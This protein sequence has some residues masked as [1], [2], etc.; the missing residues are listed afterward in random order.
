MGNRPQ[1]R[2]CTLH[3]PTGLQP[4]D[5]RQ[6]PADATFQLT[7][8]AI[9]HRL[10]A[11][12]HGHIERAAYLHTVEIWS[13]NANNRKGMPANRELSAYHIGLAAVFTLPVRIAE[14]GSSGRAFLLIVRGKEQAA[15]CGLNAQGLEEL[16]ADPEALHVVNFTGR[17]NIELRGSPG[18]N[19]GK[20][21]LLRV[22]LLP[23][24]VGQVGV[25]VAEGA[26][27]A[28]AVV[29]GDSRKFLG[30]LDRQRA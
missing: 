6:P 29:D 24:G 22:N 27:G 9:N 26:A 19:A 28:I 17:R 4:A 18:K 5:R 16:P 14:D 10:G 8:F 11:Q 23:H 7:A 21:L 20:A 15:Q 30:V 1:L 25:P 13:S 2:R 12:G 3:A